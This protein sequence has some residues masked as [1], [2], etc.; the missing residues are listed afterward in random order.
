MF[1]YY[2][3][4]HSFMYVMLVSTFKAEHFVYLLLC[5]PLLKYFVERKVI[6]MDIT[7]K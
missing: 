5:L 3:V 6:V 1:K 4:Y 7:R 2:I